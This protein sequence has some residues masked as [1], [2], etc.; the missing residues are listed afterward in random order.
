MNLAAGRTA[1]RVAGT[2]SQRAVQGL[3][4]RAPSVQRNVAAKVATGPRPVTGPG[5]K[6]VQIN[7]RDE[8]FDGECSHLLLLPARGGVRRQG[9]HGP[10]PPDTAAGGAASGAAYHEAG[11]TRRHATARRTPAWLAHAA[12]QRRAPIAASAADA[13][14]CHQRQGGS[15]LQL[16]VQQRCSQGGSARSLARALARVRPDRTATQRCLT[17]QCSTVS[18]AAWQPRQQCLW[19]AAQQ[20][21]WHVQRCACCPH[22]EQHVSCAQL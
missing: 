17:R 6:A 15:P 1:G 4:V 10:A 16:A 12:H 19:H 22:T 5:A 18:R 14:A 3:P 13:K 8:G 7:L 11:A 2:Q 21:L 9:Q 20:C